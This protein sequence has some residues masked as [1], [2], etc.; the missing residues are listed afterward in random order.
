MFHKFI[1]TCFKSFHVVGRSETI[2]SEKC[3]LEIALETIRW[4]KF[5]EI[6]PSLGKDFSAYLHDSIISASDRERIHVANIEAEYV[7]LIRHLS[8]FTI[9][10]GSIIL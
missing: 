9:M 8:W 7:H 2:L 6:L 4:E 10:V 5:L 3:H 1:S